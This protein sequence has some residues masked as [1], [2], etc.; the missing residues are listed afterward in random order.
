MQNEQKHTQFV[1]AAEVGDALGVNIRTILIWARKGIIPCLR[2]SSR[3][4][5]FDMK[6]V[7]AALREKAIQLEKECSR[8]VP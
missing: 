3:V 4:I 7:E 2:L 1:S 8:C 6:E 5:R